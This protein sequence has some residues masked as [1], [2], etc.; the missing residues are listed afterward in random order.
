M[1]RYPDFFIAG[2][3]KC[4]TTSLYSYLRG[5]PDILMPAVKEPHYFAQELSDLHVSCRSEAAYL[6]LFKDAADNAVWGEASV[7]YLFSGQA[8]EKALQ[9]NQSAKFIILARNPVDMFFSL[10]AQSLK[11]MQEDI[12]DP[13]EAWNAQSDR[14]TGKRIP[15]TNMQVEHLYY[16]DICTLGTQIEHMVK[17]VPQNQRL[18]ILLDDLEADPKGVYARVLAFLGVPD[19][20][21]TDFPVKN[22]KR[23]LRSK[24]LEK[25]IARP[26]AFLNPLRKP[27]HA[28]GIRP[29]SYL[30]ALNKSKAPPANISAEFYA[31]LENEFHSEIVKLESIF[32]RDLSHWYRTPHAKAA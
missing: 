21:R 30:N 28:L 14:K 1:T 23:A 19:D 31:R 9:A 18:L 25:F 26:P 16:Y 4:G 5:H 6:G 20:G 15:E 2:A 29:L 24:S 32:Q 12:T 13:E 22:P 7:M 3:P 17:I 11:K 27:L 8:I 10:H